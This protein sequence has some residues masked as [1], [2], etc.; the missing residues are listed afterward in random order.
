MVGELRLSYVRFG[1]VRLGLVFII[2]C[3]ISF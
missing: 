1:E 2:V 3:N